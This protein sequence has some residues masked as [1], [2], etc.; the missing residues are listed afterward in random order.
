MAKQKSITIIPSIIPF[1]YEDLR[2][3]VQVVRSAVARVQL[4]VKDGSY[5]PGVAWPYDGADR[6]F[7]EALKRQDEGLPYWQDVDYEVDLLISDP[8]R[9]MEEWILAGAACLIVHVEEAGDLDTLFN[10][11]YEK[12]IE[13]ALALR[14]STDIAVLEGFAERAVF[15]QCMGSD[16]IGEQ[17]VQLDP[18][19]YDTVRALHSRWPSATIGVDIGVNEETLPMLVEA[20]A[21]RF[22]VGSAVYE[23]GEPKLAIQR[24]NHLAEAPN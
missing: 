19:A 16:H 14:P 22:A 11:A 21:T 23:S 13:L 6:V 18:T 5:A 9:R 4:D 8:L 1:S 24:L 3:H 2:E 12:R 17:G 15:V 20:G 7:F 10:L